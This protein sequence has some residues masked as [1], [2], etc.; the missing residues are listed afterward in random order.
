MSTSVAPSPLAEVETC[1]MSCL[2]LF[3]PVKYDYSIN[4]YQ[5]H[6]LSP[7]IAVNNETKI[8]SFLQEPHPSYL[9]IA[10]TEI[11][12][13]MRITQADGSDIPPIHP[14]PL[15]KDEERRHRRRR[16]KFNAG[17]GEA[18]IRPGV[19]EIPEMPEPEQEPESERE[20]GRERDRNAA[21]AEAERRRE[22][23]RHPYQNSHHRRHHGRERQRLRA[24]VGESRET[25]SPKRRKERDP[26]V[27]SLS[28][29]SSS[30]LS[31]IGGISHT[32]DRNGAQL[33]GGYY[34]PSNFDGL[35]RESPPPPPPN[36]DPPVPTPFA[37]V[38][39]DN[40]PGFLIFED[41]DLQINGSSVN[42]MQGIYNILAVV[43]ATLT[44][45]EDYRKSKAEMF[46]WADEQS[47]DNLDCRRP[48][49]YRSRAMLFRESRWVPICAPV[50]ASFHTSG[51]YVIPMTQIAWNFHLASPV[52]VLKSA[53]ADMQFRYELRNVR[54]SVKRAHLNEGLNLAIEKRLL[55][56]PASYSYENMS[57][58]Y[59][60]IP[61]GQRNYSH[62]NLF[63]SPT[64]PLEA[65]CFAIPSSKAL[66]SFST[67]ILD[68]RGCGITQASIWTDNQRCPPSGFNHDW[69]PE[70]P[71][72]IMDAFA[73][74]WAND[75]V[76]E[77]E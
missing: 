56:M 32:P 15:T 72:G 48:S 5:E 49:S 60:I 11:L 20:R 62:D 64:L 34:R 74:L 30:P 10:N 43:L 52:C 8:I 1:A 61:Q 66:G 12:F 46:L 35:C 2:N 29:S 6:L 26:R 13:E 58:R 47:Y 16:P 23:H 50:M 27:A 73:A 59:L 57:C 69:S 42:T 38:N 17:R 70:N 44:Y 67:S 77:S 53:Q 28:S 55:S 31:Q 25:P 9:A 33:A 51:K 36:P 22:R 65:I 41:L 54:L 24:A 71:N 14:A 76:F 19:P 40:A 18:S 39:T 7:I 37:G 68:F 3:D 4:Q 63:L 21:S 45:G 75:N